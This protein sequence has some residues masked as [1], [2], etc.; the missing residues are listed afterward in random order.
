[1]LVKSMR[2]RE[3]AH[4]WPKP[5]SRRPVRRFLWFPKRLM[6]P[7]CP[8]YETRWLEWGEWEQVLYPLPLPVGVCYERSWRNP[9]WVDERW[10]YE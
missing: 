9:K 1:M 8:A 10:M 2:H 4:M 5:G 7:D 6:L 3:R